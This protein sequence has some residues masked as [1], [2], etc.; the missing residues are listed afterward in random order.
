MVARGSARPDIII[1]D[2]NLPGGL[3]GLQVAADVRETLDREIPVVIL[4]G[5]ISTVTLRE[6]ARCGCVQLNKPVTADELTRIVRSLLTE[7]RGA[8]LGVATKPPVEA[9]RRSP[10][11]PAAIAD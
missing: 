5:D 7:F 10:A 11:P 1:A 2:F 8:R 9:A 6:I 4:T 3:T